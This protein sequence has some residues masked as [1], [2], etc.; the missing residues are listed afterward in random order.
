MQIT[1]LD[2]LPEEHRRAAFRLYF[3]TLID[4]FGPVLGDV[5]SAEKALADDLASDMCLTAIQDGELVGIM[6]FQTSTRSFIDPSFTAMVRVYGLLGATYRLFGLAILKYTPA[7]DE[8]Y[9]DGVA[10]DAK[11]RSK[12]AGS[13]LFDMV[14]RIAIKKEARIISLDVIDTNPR[15]RALYERLGFTAV[16]ESSMTPWNKLFKFPFQSSTLMG[17]VCLCRMMPFRSTTKVSGTPYTPQSMP[18]RPS[19]SKALAL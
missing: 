3:N 6:S 2:H 18:T 5:S 17:P 13:A 1:C 19:A 4:K 7:R 9:V 16:R 14:E 11:H 8:V 12:G 10:V 15:A